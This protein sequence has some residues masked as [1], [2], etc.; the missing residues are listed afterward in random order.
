MDQKISV[1]LINLDSSADRLR[2]MQSE[3]DRV[4]LS[5]ERVPGILASA[6]PASLREYFCDGA[7]AIVAP[8]KLGEVGCFAAHLSVHR[9]LAEANEDGLAALILEDDAKLPDNLTD[10]LSSLLRTLPPQW[11]VV[12]LSNPPKRA[13]VPIARVDGQHQ[14]VRYSKIPNFATA[15]LLSASGAR[16]LVRPGL[17]VHAF[18]EYLRRPWLNG[19]DTFGVVP[20]P[21]TENVFQS[22]IDAVEPRKPGRANVLA[23][24][25]RKSDFRNLVGRI[26][27][28]VSTLGPAR[29]AGCL[30]VNLADKPAKR[31]FR[32]TLIHRSALWLKY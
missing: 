5:F 7:G 2:H 14:L 20:A 24:S 6:L 15:Y 10:I 30:L 3:L 19:L 22:T 25:I 23:K 4:D 8:L 27:F 31:L 11:D 16:K 18:D 1:F 21:I 29:W 12:R 28:D 26:S 13:Y 32:R 17:R 9:R